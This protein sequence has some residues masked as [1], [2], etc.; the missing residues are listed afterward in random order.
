MKKKKYKK[1]LV[2]GSGAFGTSVANILAHNFENIILM[3]RSKNIADDINGCRENKC[4]LPGQKLEKNIKA[5][6]SWK[7]VHME[8]GEI[9]LLVFGLPSTAI[10]GYIFENFK[11]VEKILSGNIPAVSL[12]K[13]IDPVTLELTD[14]LYFNFFSDYRDNFTFLS[15]PSFAKEI[16]DKQVTL[17]SLAGRSKKVLMAIADMMQTPYFKVLPN[18][19]VKGVLLGGALKNILAIAGGILEGLGFNYNTRAAMITRGIAE[20]TSFGKVMNARPETFY[21]L[22]GMGDLILSTTGDLSRNKNFGLEIAK[23][24]K[25][26]EILGEVGY[27]VEGYKT[28]LAAYRMSK[29][30]E[31]KARIFNAVYQVLYEDEKPMDIIKYLMKIPARFE[32]D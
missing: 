16:V 21:G 18:Y 28:T 2:I 6:L 7:D 31:I 22:S 20:I 12:A 4:Y 14:D 8:E 25:P 17:V 11:N 29:K 15:G 19:D 26:E 10:T 3:G 1:A 9:D 24:R 5:V 23:G 13:G 30:Y 27:V 32:I